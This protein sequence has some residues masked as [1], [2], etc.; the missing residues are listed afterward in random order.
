VCKSLLFVSLVITKYVDDSGLGT[1]L[2]LRKIVD[3]D[4]RKNGLSSSRAAGA[5]ESS[6]TFII[7]PC[8][9]LLF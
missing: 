1:G 6:R 3:N 2:V 9:E 7:D 8:V 4:S 5:E